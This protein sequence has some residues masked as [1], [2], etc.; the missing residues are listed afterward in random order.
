MTEDPKNTPF[1]LRARAAKAYRIAMAAT[2]VGARGADWDLHRAKMAEARELYAQAAEGLAAAAIDSTNDMAVQTA[3]AASALWTIEAV[4]RSRAST[5]KLGEADPALERGVVLLTR[6]E[7]RA[8]L[9]WVVLREIQAVRDGWIEELKVQKETPEEDSARRQATRDS[10]ERAYDAFV[11]DLA[12]LAP[13][14][15][16]DEK[17][18]QE[19]YAAMCNMQWVKGDHVFSVSW[20]SA[21]GLVAS[22]RDPKETYLDWYCSGITRE[23]AVGEGTVTDRVQDALGAFGWAPKE[24]DE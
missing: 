4:E 23:G 24:W 1:E 5:R 19:V 7:A 15:R 12:H 17:F 14:M 11:T 9:P 18:A 21:G 3:C 10:E 2:H 6:I 22:F 8:S 13:R 20:R 16:E